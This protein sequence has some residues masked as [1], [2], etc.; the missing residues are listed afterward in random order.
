MEEKKNYIEPNEAQE[1]IDSINKMKDASLKRV[2]PIPRS[3]GAILSIFIGTHIALLGAGIRDYNT[4]IILLI[5]IMAIAIISKSHS[6]GVMERTVI[7]TRTIII[8]V[9]CIIPTYFLTII[10][11]Q[12]LKS[13]FGFDWAPYMIGGLVIVGFYSLIE[14]A[15]HLYY[16]KFGKD[17]N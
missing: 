9:F 2:T 13:R 15:R 12:Y 17:N 1:A 4:I 6:G 10:A 11:G 5:L 3:L 8:A 14:S 7:S 16:S